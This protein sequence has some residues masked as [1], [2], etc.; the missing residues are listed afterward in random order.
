MEKNTNFIY[1]NL[2]PFKWFVL[3]NFPFLEADFDALTEWQLFCKLGKEI[4]KII[5]N[6]NMLGTQVEELTDYVSNYFDNLD[7]Q[8]EINNKLNDMAK[9]GELEEIISSYINSNAIICFNI[10]EDL[11]NNDKLVE[12]SYAKTLGKNVINDG[13]GQLFYITKEISATGVN[14]ITKINLNRDDL[15]ANLITDYINVKK[16]G[17]YGDG[18]HDDTETLQFIFDNLLSEKSTVYFP[19]GT[20]L[21]SSPINITCVPFGSIKLETKAEIKT[22]S[23]IETLFKLNGETSFFTIEGGYFNANNHA[24]YCINTDDNNKFS[25]NYKNILFRNAK[26]TCLKIRNSNSNLA[27]EHGYI[28]NCKF[29]NNVTLATALELY[30]HDYTISNC[31]MFYVT[32]GAIIKGNTDFKSTHIWAGGQSNTNLTTGIKF[33]IADNLKLIDMYFDGINTCIDTESNNAYI[34]LTNSFIFF[35]SEGTYEKPIIIK[36]NFAGRN[37]ITNNT[38]KTY[39]IT[40]SILDFTNLDVNNIQNWRNHLSSNEEHYNSGD[41]FNYNVVNMGNNINLLENSFKCIKNNYVTLTNG[42]YYKIGYIVTPTSGVSSMDLT[43]SFGDI[44]KYQQRVRIALYNNNGNVTTNVAKSTYENG[45]GNYGIAIGNLETITDGIGNTI[46][47]CPI[48]LHVISNQGNNYPISINNNNKTSNSVISL[49]S[50]NFMK[51][52]SEP[53][54]LLDLIS[55]N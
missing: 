7:V 12:G 13:G 1:K 29:Y 39:G 9:T 11:I 53:A 17:V 18:I 19:N 42:K 47:A 49:F 22:N 26:I 36:N 21:I 44:S 35:A 33:P 28:Y 20:Y 31:E 2:S 34:T 55:N 37:I 43:F 25:F 51:E 8:E 45:E 6:T 46:K 32:T 3:E 38:I 27:S 4:N 16:L 52:V 30:A 5:N 40:Y 54:I 15:Y 24:N 14:G 23:D 48:Y 10:L 41:N 50:E